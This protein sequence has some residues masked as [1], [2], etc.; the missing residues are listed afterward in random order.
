MN[1]GKNYSKVY[2]SLWKRQIVIF[3]VA[4]VLGGFGIFSAFLGNTTL[5]Y[6]LFLGALVITIIISFIL[7]CPACGCYICW[8]SKARGYKTQPYAVVPFDKKCPQCGVILR[9]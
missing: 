6:I 3:A 7:K 1:E 2:T 8:N 4:L 5:F 9:E